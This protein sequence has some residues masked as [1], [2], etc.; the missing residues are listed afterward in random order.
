MV[1]K[2]P[3][4]TR[5]ELCKS[6]NIN[7]SIVTQ[8]AAFLEND[9]WITSL[10]AHTKKLPLRMNATRLNVAGVEIQPEY[11]NLA[12]CDL[13]GKKLYEKSW[14][15]DSS[16]LESFL[17]VM[18]PYYLHESGLEI[19]AL[20]VAM[21]G[22]IDTASHTLLASQPLKVSSPMMLPER[23]GTK[24]FPVFYDNDARCIGWGLV[25]FQREKGN[26]LLHYMKLVEH[27]P[28]TDEYRRIIH[29][30]ALFFDQKSFNGSRHRA[31]EVRMQSHLPYSDGIKSFGDY[32]TRLRLKSKP[33]LFGK[34]LDSLV[35]DI[36]YV[37]T[38]MDVDKVFILGSLRQHKD[39][40]VERFGE[41]S[42]K[43]SYYPQLGEISVEFP[44]LTHDSMTLG[45]AGMA[46]ERLF[47]VPVNEHPSEFYRAIAEKRQG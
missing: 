44:E 43:A 4:I 10:D 8:L 31:G 23:I 9:G 12:I 20:G 5:S 18:L 19:G 25:C 30:M 27:D 14:A 26:F 35:F 1:Y 46:I 13:E 38:L 15:R 42:E 22:I 24:E 40:I 41:I 39:R 28:P 36:G 29:G 47:S 37:A 17:N 7:K 16:D 11:C 33:E 2:C 32:M 3:G 21:P 6:L 34:Y 45:A